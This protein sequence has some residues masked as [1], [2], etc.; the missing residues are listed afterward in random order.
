[1]HFQITLFIIVQCP[2]KVGS[3]LAYLQTTPKR[4][5]ANFLTNFCSFH[6]NSVKWTLHFAPFWTSSLLH[7]RDDNVLTGGSLAGQQSLLASSSGAPQNC[8]V[9][10]VFK[11]PVLVMFLTAPGTSSGESACLKHFHS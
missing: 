2:F 8:T 4:D 3:F 1:V 5:V 7:G 11:L 10:W 9:V 6:F